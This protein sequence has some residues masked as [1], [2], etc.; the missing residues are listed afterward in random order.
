MSLGAP[1]FDDFL[2]PRQQPDDA[3]SVSLSVHRGSAIPRNN[4]APHDFG[5]TGS[6]GT[7]NLSSQG[8]KRNTQSVQPNSQTKRNTKVSSTSTLRILENAMK[9][10]GNAAETASSLS[11]MT[12]N[13][14]PDGMINLTNNSLSAMAGG[15]PGGSANMPRASAAFLRARSG[16]ISTTPGQLWKELRESRAERGPPNLAS[17]SEE[18]CMSSYQP[19]LSQRSIGGPKHSLSMTSLGSSQMALP[20][21]IVYPSSV[22]EEEEN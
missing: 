2:R 10:R 3:I 6:G 16:S 8:S 22:P 18:D 1:N 21:E 4:W 7:M 17:T 13:S 20:T 19:V 15:G 5:G 12:S 11:S 14:T 9:R